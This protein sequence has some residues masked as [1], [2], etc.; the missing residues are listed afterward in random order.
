MRVAYS[1]FFCLSALFENHL[2]AKRPRL[3]AYYTATVCGRLQWLLLKQFLT[4]F[5]IRWHNA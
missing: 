1:L 2:A 4:S 5:S 3:I